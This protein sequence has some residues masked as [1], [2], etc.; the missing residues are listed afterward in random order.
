MLKQDQ[1]KQLAQR[2]NDLWNSQ[3]EKLYDI[4]DFPSLVT[5]ARVI[6][7]EEKFDK[8]SR[9]GKRKSRFCPYCGKRTCG[10]CDHD[11]C[12]GVYGRRGWRKLGDYDG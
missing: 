6:L 12:L 5:L 8:C 11:N 10:N 7:E 1:A 3:R 4:E 9:C 2:V